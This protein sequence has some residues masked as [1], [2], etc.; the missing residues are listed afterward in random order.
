MTTL[1]DSSHSELD[2]IPVIHSPKAEVLGIRFNAF[3]RA[4]AIQ[5]IDYFISEHHPHSRQVVFANAHTVSACWKDYEL[6]RS[7]DTADLV[8]ADGMSIVWGGRLIGVWLPE[9]VTGPELTLELCARAAERGYRLYFLGS[10]EDNVTLLKQRLLARWPSLQFV[11]DY[12]PPMCDRLDNVQNQSIVEHIKASQA[13]ILLVGMSMPKQEKWIAE[14]RHLIGV[15]VALGVGAAFDFISGRIPRAPYRLQ[16]V[17]LEWLYRLWL[18]PRRLW[19][20]YLLGNIIFLTHLFWAWIKYQ[21]RPH[22]H[23][24]H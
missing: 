18:E 15:P 1:D 2:R 5:Q 3:T 4:R 8:L 14:N 20:R 10:S 6:R 21:L 17:G 19:R 7:V 13:D 11:G 12:S 16:K 23:S 9:R 22:P 24:P